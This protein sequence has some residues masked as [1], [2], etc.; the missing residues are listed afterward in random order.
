MKRKLL[1]LVLAFA[2]IISVN[3]QIV[4]QRSDLPVIGHQVITGID[5]V[6]NFDI[7][8]AGPN[9]TWDF[10]NAVA[11]SFDTSVYILVQQAPNWQLYPGADMAAYNTSS[12]GAAYGFYKNTD[13]DIAIMGVDFEMEMMPGLSYVMHLIYQQ[14]QWQYLPYHYGDNHSYNITEVGYTGVYENGN[15]TDSSKSVSHVNGTLAVDAWGTMITP[16]GSFPVLR[17]KETQ[18]FVDSVFTWENNSWVFQLTNPGNN[19]SYSWMSNQYGY[20]GE[21]YL[22]ASR[23]SN[24]SFFISQTVVN[25]NNIK[26]PENLVTISPNPATDYISINGPGKIEKAAIYNLDGQLQ[27]VSTNQ[28]LI[29]VSTLKPG[30]YFAKINNGNKVSVAKFVIK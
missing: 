17:L 4:V 15:L 14:P 21:I 25:T 12:D 23:E 16:A 13:T 5:P 24:L 8:S 11:T 1:F 10:S 20:I 27:I 19:E 18:N 26:L 6:H 2:G 29:D 9:Q 28:K 7:G 3:A 30:I 22:D